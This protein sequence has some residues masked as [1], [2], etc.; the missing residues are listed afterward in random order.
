MKKA[1][2][3]FKYFAIT[4]TALALCVILTCTGFFVISTKGVSLNRSILEESTTS[5]VLQI[6]DING[7]QI[8]PTTENFISI[9]KLSSDT[10]NAFI[11]AEDKRFY[12]HNG[13][14]YIRIGG[15]IASNIKSRSFSEGASTISQQLIKNTHLSNEKTIKRKLKEFKLTKQLENIYSKE[16]ILE[17]YLNNIYFGNGCYGIENASLHYFGKS[18]SKLSLAESALLAA[19]I[20]APSIYDIENNIEKAL[21]RRNLILNL[22]EKY[23]KITNKEKLSAQ[24]E[25]LNLKLTKLSGNNFI[26]NEIIEEASLILG[27]TQ[28]QIKNSNIKIYSH[29]D[30]SLQNKIQQIIKNNYSKLESSP[31]VSS[32]IIDNKTNGIAAIIGNK[33]S[34]LSKKQPGST[35]K[36]ILVYAPAIELGKISPATKILDEKI[37]ISGYSPENADK[38]YHGYVSV[39]E[40]LKNSYNIP[41][42]KI[43]QETGIEQSQNIANKFGIEFS[44]SD[45]NLAIALGGFTDGTT[46]KQL[47]DAYSAL[48]NNG[49]FSSSKYINKIETNNKIVYENKPSKTKAIS[50]STAY[51][52]TNILQD[53]TKTGTAKRLKDFSFD[54]ASKTGTV[55]SANSNTDSYNISYTTNHTILSYIG[56]T[57]MPPN[58]NG[59]TYPTMLTKDVL[60]ELYKTKKPQNFTPPDSVVIK[61][62]DKTDYQNNIISQTDNIRNSITETFAKNNLPQKT[63]TSLNLKLDVFN[64]ENKKPILCFHTSQNYTYNIIRKQNE[65]EEI[66]SSLTNINDSKIAKF[67]DKTAENDKIYEYFVEICEKSS[68]KTFK[69]NSVKLKTYSIRT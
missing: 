12:N 35:I 6:F 15:A 33:S 23:G 21:S 54:I 18:A 52:L 25:E 4:T 51:L 19:T 43:L 17:M 47:A 3:F 14:D 30:L 68:N 7:N 50:S 48:A 20:N 9:K 40:S 61:H 56:G 58:I 1:K 27:K 55:G 36:P 2:Q 24:N 5:S 11:C 60:S 34:I 26:Y 45:N 49:L 42:V 67:E 16:E 64:F 8:K 32:I 66:I 39:R 28:T 31:N 53:T 44:E 59:A 38:K 13:L 37:N 29:I 57:S 69:T 10:K 41:A 22:M 46:L 63:K 65:K 62:I